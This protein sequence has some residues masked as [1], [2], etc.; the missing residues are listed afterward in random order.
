MKKAIDLHTHSD[1]SDGTLSPSQLARQAKDEGLSAIALTDHDT[2]TGIAEFMTECEKLGIEGIP[3]I[4]ISTDYPRLLHIVGLYAHGEEYDRI[5]PRLKNA[6]RNRNIKM[7]RRLYEEF[8]ISAGEIL[9][10]DNANE[11]SAGRL[12]MAKA[13]VRRG[14]ADE[15]SEAFEKY[16]KRGRLCYVEKES[17]SPTES[18]K[19][20]KRCGGIAIWA[21]PVTAVD[22]EEE[23]LKMAAELQKAGLDAMEC[24]YNN[25][26]PE[27]NRICR[28]VCQG[29][30]LLQSGG[31]DFHGANKPGVLLGRVTAGDGHIPY[32]LLDGLKTKLY[33][34]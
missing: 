23:M 28:S 5:V 32:E 17:S 22:T 16:L 12:H 33:Q 27:Q 24:Y 1:C 3:G 4:E 20:I 8:G 18:V 6:R 9:G 13:I 21:H 31:S 34:K 29:L 15:V 2:N 11:E 10:A 25:F 14:I 26:T 30:G 19:L 7:F